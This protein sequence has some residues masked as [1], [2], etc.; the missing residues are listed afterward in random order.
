MSDPKTATQDQ[1]PSEKSTTAGN[2][3]GVPV[4]HEQA[5][6][7]TSEEFAAVDGVYVVPTSDPDQSGDEQPAAGDFKDLA[8]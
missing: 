6:E 7:G 3:Q 2:A 4:P 1:Q 8:K 5:A